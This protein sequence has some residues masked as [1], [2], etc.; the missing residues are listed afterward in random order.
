MLPQV[1]LTVA[2]LPECL[3][4]E[5]LGHYIPSSCERVAP[6]PRCSAESFQ[7]PALPFLLHL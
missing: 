1:A 4:L 7:P 6:C 2:L 5:S 3:G